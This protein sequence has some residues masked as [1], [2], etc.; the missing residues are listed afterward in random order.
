MPPD[1]PEVLQ[2][3]RDVGGFAGTAAFDEPRQG[4]AV[5]LEIVTHAIQPFDLG[6]PHQPLRGAGGFADAIACQPLQRVV[7]LTR[8]GELESRVGSYG[9]EHLVERTSGHRG[10]GSQQEALVDQAA[11]AAQCVVAARPGLPHDRQGLPRLPRSENDPAAR[12]DVGT[13]AVRSSPVGDSSRRPS[14]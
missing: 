3:P 14:R 10:L 5:A 9:F 1:Q 7:P 4:G 2:A 11:A 6:R 12:R 13:H 8:R